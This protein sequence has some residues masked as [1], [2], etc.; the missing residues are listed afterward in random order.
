[1]AYYGSTNIEQGAAGLGEYFA[2][3][4]GLGALGQTY[5]VRCIRAWRSECYRQNQHDQAAFNRC[6][7]LNTTRCHPEFLNWLREGKPGGF[8][9]GFAL[10][11]QVCYQ[12][13]PHDQRGYTDCIANLRREA[14]HGM[15]EYFAAQGMGAFSLGTMSTGRLVAAG[16]VVGG[17]IGLMAAARKTKKAMPAAIGAGAGA[18]AGFLLHKVGTHPAATTA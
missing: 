18:A 10:V 13:H 3:H 1:M 8:N 9:R 4:A 17:L 6:V 2:A 11:R 14:M 7:E 16:A 15:G 12:D 5:D